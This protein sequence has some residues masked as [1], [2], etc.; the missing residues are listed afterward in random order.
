VVQ[1]DQV[2]RDRELYTPGDPAVTALSRAVQQLQASI[3]EAAEVGGVMDVKTAA[4]TLNLSVA[5]V[6]HLCRNGGLAGEKLGGAWR[7]SRASVEARLGR[8]N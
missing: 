2:A 7:I 8:R 4:Q 3:E 1:L 6:T 5:M